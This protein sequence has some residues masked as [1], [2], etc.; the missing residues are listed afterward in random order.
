[1]ADP[2]KFVI[3]IAI[4]CNTVRGVNV[5]CYGSVHFMDNFPDS[6][7]FVFTSYLGDI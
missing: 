5:V 3:I 2:E 7:I 1:M 4:S 6:L